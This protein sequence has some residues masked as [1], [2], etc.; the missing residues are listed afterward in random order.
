MTLNVTAQP[1]PCG[2]VVRGIDLRQ[3]LDAHTLAA[4]RA[5]WLQHQVL[6]FVDQTLTLEDL[7]RFA[8][9]I[10]PYGQD[11]Y[12]ESVPGHPH[13]AQVKR[14][15]DETSTIFADNFHSDWSFLARPP[16]ATLLYGD[17]IPPVGG[18]TLFANQYAAWDGL[19]PA[20]QALLKD[21]QGV[22][23]AR[24]GYARNGRYGEGDKG[25]SMAIRFDDSALAT[26]TQPIARVHP[27]TG[28]TALFVSPGYTIG[29]DGMPDAEAQP[30]LL[31]LFRHQAKPEF[32]YRHVW[33][34]GTLLLWDNRCLVHAATG[35]YDGHRRLLHRITVGE[36]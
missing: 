10:G 14:E 19:S 24:R 29:I 32:V 16:A 4:V 1:A 6:A 25:R 21:K 20:M 28:R 30:L 35:G 9:C 31:E 27:E 15:A 7:E 3:T 22:H 36:R 17:V 13:V 2:A 33:Q 26:Q 34:Q 18:D 12:F 5:A 23:S 8:L 11:P